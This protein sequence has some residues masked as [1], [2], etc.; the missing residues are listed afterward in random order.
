MAFSILF[1]EPAVCSR[2]EPACFRDLNLDQFLGPLISQEEN[3][4]LSPIFW[5]PLP[6]EAQVCYRQEIL[7]DL[8][9][10]EVYS[11][12][13]EFSREICSLSRLQT[14][15]VEDLQ[16]GDPWRCHYLLYGHIL[17]YSQRYVRCLEQL[18]RQL[19]RMDLTS[20]GLQQAAERFQ[21]LRSS[22]FYQTMVKAQTDLRRRFDGLHYCM[23][24]R[25]G[26]VRV[27][28]LEGEEDLSRKILSVFQKFRQE[29]QRDYRQ[30]LREDPYAD[31]VEAAVLQCLS[32]VYPREFQ[33]LTAYV[34]A[35]SEFM[36][37]G[38]LTFCREIRFYLDWIQ[39]TEPL[40]R[41]GLPFCF[42]EVHGDLCCNDF[43]DLALADRIGKNTVANSA[44]LKPG[45]RILV[46]TGPNQGGKTT[47]AR[48]LGQLHYLAAL[49]LDVP[50]TSAQLG[51]TD[52]VLTHF[53][54]EEAET[55]TGGR[56][57]NDL[58]RLR[59]LLETAT[60]KS[61]VVINEIFASTAAGNAAVLGRKML[62]AL[63]RKGVTAVLVTFLSELAVDN[64]AAVSMMSTVDPADAGIR[65][66]RVVR[67][68]PDGRTYAMTLARRHQL[69][70]EQMKRRIQP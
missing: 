33:A 52:Q 9:N 25:Y 44:Y 40:R 8:R 23:Q 29:G 63:T 48:A 1:S 68:P 10:Q 65:T 69:T 64:P 3:V 41:A 12:A 24:I 56:L 21:S 16:S 47:F 53:E 61:F 32:K 39:R 7:K 4:D 51:L 36:D 26:T 27:K 62:R 60:E 31:H 5:T 35:F 42:P 66:F 59:D 2:K 54:R 30:S 14:Q 11:A 45:Q 46:V 17:D 13:D 70:Y 18:V 49:G 57:Q 6:S 43:F 22:G 38:L 20:E 19:P 28:K 37:Q 55:D 67:K 58:E 34:Q 15:A 50:G